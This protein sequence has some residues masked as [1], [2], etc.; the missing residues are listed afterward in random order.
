MNKALT[1]VVSII[2]AVVMAILAYALMQYFTVEFFQRRRPGRIKKT[3][4]AAQI[5]PYLRFL[6]IPRWIQKRWAHEECARQLRHAGITLNARGYASFRWMLIWLAI[7]LSMWLLLA[8]RVDLVS[9]FLSLLIF[10]IAIAGPGIWLTLQTERRKFEIE[11]SLPDFLD[12]LA[13]GLEAGLGFEIA[14]RRTAANFPGLLGDELRRAIRK[15][16]RGHTTSESLAELA[17]RNPSNDLR[18]FIAAVRQAEKLGTSLVKSLRVQ[19]NVL[20]ARRRRRAQEASRR[21]PIIIVFPLVFCFLPALMIIY[22]APPLL[23]L[24]LGR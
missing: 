19:T 2:V 1:I 10:I 4:I 8:R 18:A 12:H 22:I 6:P 9:T 5:E 21:L 15:I 14:L 3:S 7:V 13:L 24:F 16:D 11:L 17:E 23:H 20:R